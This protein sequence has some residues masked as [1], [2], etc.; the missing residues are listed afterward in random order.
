M[1]TFVST[2][3]ALCLVVLLYVYAFPPKSSRMSKNGVPFFTPSVTH[4]ETGKALDV[5][6]LVRHFKGE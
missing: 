4:P 6:L 2:I 1:R 3:A 5:N